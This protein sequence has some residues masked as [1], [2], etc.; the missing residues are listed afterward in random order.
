VKSTTDGNLAKTVRDHGPESKKTKEQ[1][2]T[3]KESVPTNEN[4]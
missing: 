3:I 4:L 1:Q 2:P